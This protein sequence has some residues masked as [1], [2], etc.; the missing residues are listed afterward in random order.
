[1]KETTRSILGTR[2]K[3][4][5][6]NLL[7]LTDI[8]QKAKVLKFFATQENYIVE[9]INLQGIEIN[10]E[11][12]KNQ[13]IVRALKSIGQYKAKGARENKKVYCNQYVFL[14][15]LKYVYPNVEAKNILVDNDKFIT[16][17]IDAGHEYT[18][19]C[20][21]ITKHIPVEENIYT[22]FVNLINEKVFGKRSGL[23]SQIASKEQI[24]ELDKIQTKV[25]ALIEVGHINNYQEAE[26][27]LIC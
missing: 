17:R 21:A 27:Y 5:K 26:K 6:N 13:G 11:Q 15:V 3:Q 18:E 1:M 20:T 14:A 2:V 16:D 23:L 22:N 24:K 4:I 8:E 7:C 19:L 25:S 9:L 12:I 10:Q